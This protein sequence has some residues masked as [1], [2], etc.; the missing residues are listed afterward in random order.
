MKYVWHFSKDAIVVVPI[1]GDL[2][3]VIYRVSYRLSAVDGIYQS[4]HKGIAV[5]S[6]P[7]IDSFLPYQQITKEI[8][9]DWLSKQI[10][11]VEQIKADLAS[12][13]EDLK[14]E[15]LTETRDLPWL[16]A[17]GAYTED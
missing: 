9:C 5:F 10:E 11:G 7:I 15:P 3:D 13:I 2:K 12:K 4:H 17:V 6:S 1:A 14:S 16:Q 8:L